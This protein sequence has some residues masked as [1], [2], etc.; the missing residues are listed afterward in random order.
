M[1]SVCF[2][3]EDE[4]ENEMYQYSMKYKGFS[5]F[6]KRLIQS[7]MSGKVEK[8]QPK[9]SIEQLPNDQVVIKDEYLRQLI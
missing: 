1:K 7:S 4:F 9:M 5:T 2:N 8:L 3:L 6:I